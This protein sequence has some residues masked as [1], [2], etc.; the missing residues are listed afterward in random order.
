MPL[1]TL[2]FTKMGRL[3]STLC[4][5]SSSFFTKFSTEQQ[6]SWII[7]TILNVRTGNDELEIDT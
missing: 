2:A 4:K 7:E 1:K 6:I 5:I 3:I